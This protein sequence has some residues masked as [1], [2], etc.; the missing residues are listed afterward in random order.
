M[1]WLQKMKTTLGTVYST[2]IDVVLNTITKNRAYFLKLHLQYPHKDD[3]ALLR[4]DKA[5]V[6]EID[7]GEHAIGKVEKKIEL[8]TM[9]R[10]LRLHFKGE[11]LCH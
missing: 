2:L 3:K 11:I 6:M 9:A 7:N 8:A 1:E 4:A 5:Y 10:N